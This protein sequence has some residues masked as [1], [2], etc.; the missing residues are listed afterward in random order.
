MDYYRD[1]NLEHVIYDIFLEADTYLVE[2]V[3][4]FG[5]DY[6]VSNSVSGKVRQVARDVL[7]DRAS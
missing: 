3:V 2:G 5:V 7:Q 4:Q 1:C 6:G